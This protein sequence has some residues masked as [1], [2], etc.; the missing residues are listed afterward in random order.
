MNKLGVVYAELM[1]QYGLHLWQDCSA[2]SN[3]KD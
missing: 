1:R 2:T 3:R